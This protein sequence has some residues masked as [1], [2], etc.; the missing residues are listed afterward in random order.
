MLFYSPEGTSSTPEDTTEIWHTWGQDKNPGVTTALM[1]Y[2]W[3]HFTAQPLLC[4]LVDSLPNC[5]AF[6]V[7][8]QKAELSPFHLL[9]P[10]TCRHP[11]PSY[12]YVWLAS[13]SRNP[14]CTAATCK[15]CGWAHIASSHSLSE[16]LSIF[17]WQLLRVH[18]CLPCYLL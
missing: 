17:S 5:S 18:V 2:M 1:R 7:S 16:R 6:W 9:P 12:L 3:G 4:L 13:L 15:G 14:Y 11:Q 10:K 8:A